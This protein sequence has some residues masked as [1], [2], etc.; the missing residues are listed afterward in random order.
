MAPVLVPQAIRYSGVAADRKG[1][2]VEAT[3]RLYAEATGGEPIW[4]ETQDISVGADGRY[5]VLLG[6]QSSNGLPQQLFAQ[7][8]GRWISVSIERAPE[9]GRS[10]LASVAY[11]MKAADAE[12]L[13]GQAAGNYV[14]RAELA[15]QIAAAAQS[16]STQAAAQSGLRPAATLTGGG[17]QGVIPMWESSDTLGDSLMY[18]LKNGETTYFGIGTSS[19]GNTL[20]VAGGLT[21]RNGLLLPAVS[22]A[23]V[24]AGQKSA[25]IIHSASSYNSISAMPQTFEF[26][27]EAV[28]LGN[29]TSNPG[30]SLTLMT[31]P[32][33]GLLAPA[34]L[35]IAPNGVV[36]FS[37]Q[38]T[39]P[40]APSLSGPN[41]FTGP[42]TLDSNLTITGNEYVNGI[43]NFTANAPMAV[44]T[45]TNTNPAQG[46]GIVGTGFTGVEGAGSNY[47]V[48]GLVPAANPANSKAAG[49]EG[50]GPIGVLGTSTLAAGVGVEASAPAYGMFGTATGASG[51]GVHGGSTSVGVDGLALGTNASVIGVRGTGPTGVQGTGQFYGVTGTAL[52]PLGVGVNAQ[53]NVTNGVGVYSTAFSTGVQGI[54]TQPDSVGVRGT[55]T[56]A[57][58]AGVVAVS[59]GPRDAKGGLPLGVN[60]QAQEGN[61]VLGI[62]GVAS[63]LYMFRSLQSGFA[64]VWGDTGEY[65]GGYPPNVYA[66]G[67]AGT[68][69]DNIAAG[70]E[71]NSKTFTTLAVQNDHPG[72]TGLFSTLHARSAAGDCGF[73]GKGDLT[74]TGQVKTLATTG[75]GAHKVETYAMQSPENW[76][77]D[78][79]FA[80]LTGGAAVVK[81]DP[82][83]AD[84]VSETADYHVFITP[85][86]DSKGLYVI[87]KTAT[88]F[89]VRESGGG[90]SSLSFDYRIVA[91][92]RGYE[93]ERLTDVTEPFNAANHA[94]DGH[95]NPIVKPAH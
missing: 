51:I 54:A 86:G 50:L 60:G 17:I 91:K 8:Q 40:G 80:R 18:E 68:A 72:P 12:T 73:G 48:M 41:T 42:L 93:A 22:Q 2:T 31:G 27:W 58:G 26:G 90:A 3:F 77:E 64:G 92:R 82:A 10:L 52:S 15:S 70:F 9:T 30:A 13:A 76:M 44:L 75:G 29:N 94:L 28:P 85:N 20:D 46:E 34:G 35:S 14:T 79:G 21:V 6:S 38:Q 11:A 25:P 16:L 7:G 53:A 83:F 5:A 57:G 59:N 71:N 36:T 45:A 62:S 39:F 67:V 37:E 55:T 66:A 95:T 87:G 88:S 65:G 23:N 69:D 63:Q 49:V 1:D 84:T 56:G 89:E 24:G 43:G 47:G 19:P 81:I 74:C 33:Q 4:Q 78:F 32:S 61:G